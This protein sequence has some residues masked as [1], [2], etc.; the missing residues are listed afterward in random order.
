MKDKKPF[1]PINPLVDFYNSISVKHAVTAG[2]FDIASLKTSAAAEPDTVGKHPLLELRLTRDGDVFLALDAPEG[3]APTPVP[4]DELA[5]VQGNAV[6]TRHLAWRQAAAGL[7]TPQ[8]TDVVFMSE[9]FNESGEG[10]DAPSA[11]AQSVAD[12]LVKGLKDFFGVE[13][14]AVVLSAGLGKTDV[15]IGGGSL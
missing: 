1:R 15:E 10:A 8:T 7:V 9:I 3:T 14:K 2:A 13:G 11:L 5:Y 4:A 12:D 6:L